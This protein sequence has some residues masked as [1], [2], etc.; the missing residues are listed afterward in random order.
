M[1][2]S[3]S[4]TTHDSD[5]VPENFSSFISL[6]YLI[7]L[8]FYICAGSTIGTGGLSVGDKIGIG[9]V[10][11]AF[12]LAVTTVLGIFVCCKKKH[13]YEPLPGSSSSLQGKLATHL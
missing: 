3:G 5:K 12:V 9:V 11:G 4:E 13:E 8:C 2:G 10:G 6:R 7:F 1:Q